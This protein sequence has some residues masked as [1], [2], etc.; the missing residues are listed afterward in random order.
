VS[1]ST[2]RRELMR[3]VLDLRR[4]VL[5]VMFAGALSLVAIGSAA[6]TSPPTKPPKLATPKVLKVTNEVNFGALPVGTCPLGHDPFFDPTCVPLPV[7]VTNVSDQVVDIDG[8]G[9]NQF[10]FGTMF[11]ETHFGICDVLQ[12]GDSCQITV[13]VHVVARGVAW[14]YLTFEGSCGDN[15]CTIFGYARLQVEGV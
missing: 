8:E 2:K 15:G 14:T 6:G 12:P 7:D 1:E 10:G 4:F 9:I 13:F 11:F 5:L 3:F